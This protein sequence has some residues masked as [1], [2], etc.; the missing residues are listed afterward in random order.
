MSSVAIGPKT[1]EITNQSR[2]LRFLFAPALHLS[3][4]VFPSRRNSQDR[5]AR[6]PQKQQQIPPLGFV[7]LRNYGGEGVRCGMPVPLYL[8]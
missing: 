3:E 2:P 8:W 6:C 4:T 7:R 5:S 1:R